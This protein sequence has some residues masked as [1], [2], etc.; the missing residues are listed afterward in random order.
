MDT[1]GMDTYP[2]IAS[3]A[4]AVEGAFTREIR[5][6]AARE[7]RQTLALAGFPARVVRQT[8]AKTT[9]CERPFAAR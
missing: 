5:R 9:T 3:V 4:V 8:T 7:Q 6:S 1:I 2:L